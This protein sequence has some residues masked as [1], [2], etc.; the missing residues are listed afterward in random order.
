[1]AHGLDAAG[2]L[3]IAGVFPGGVSH[4]RRRGR[5]RGLPGLR[6]CLP[7]ALC[8]SF[9][10]AVSLGAGGLACGRP[11]PAGRLVDAGLAAAGT[12]AAADAPDS[13]CHQRGAVGPLS[14]AG[15]GRH[16][17]PSAKP[18]GD[19]QRP[20]AGGPSRAGAAGCGA[21]RLVGVCV[22]FSWPGQRAAAGGPSGRG[23]AG[24]L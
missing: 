19:L 14:P 23:K 2:S 9:H 5:P 6:P 1:M 8:P 11:L 18:V 12:G 22:G 7:R 3:F 17:L 10:L 16:P 24:P 13:V 20:Q 4:A 15:A 21:L